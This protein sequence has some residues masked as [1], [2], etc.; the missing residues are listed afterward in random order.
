MKIL[1]I[2]LLFLASCLSAYSLYNPTV[3]HGVGDTTIIS[4]II[5]RSLP[6]GNIGNAPAKLPSY[7]TAFAQMVV[8]TRGTAPPVSTINMHTNPTSQNVVQGFSKPYTV[9]YRPTTVLS[10]VITPKASLPAGCS[11]VFTP[12]MVPADGGPTSAAVACSGSST[13]GAKTISFGGTSGSNSGTVTAAMNVVA[14]CLANVTGTSTTLSL[15][16]D[17]QAAV[18]KAQGGDTIILPDNFTWT[19]NLTLPYRAANDVQYITIR[20]SSAVIAGQR[21]LPS[22]SLPTL[23]S[24]TQDPVIANDFNNSNPALRT[25]HHWKVSGVRI[26]S[27]SGFSGINY[28]Y[29]YFWVPPVSAAT[30]YAQTS[31]LSHDLMFDHIFIHGADTSNDIVRGVRA[32]ANN[33][34]FVD[35]YIDNIRSQSYEANAFCQV[36]TQGGTVL[37]NNFLESAGEN[38]F[39]GAG[40]DIFNL[41]GSGYTV[42]NNYFYKRFSWRGGIYTV[43]NVLEWKSGQNAQVDHN[44]FENNWQAQQSG[45]V[46]L[47]TPRTGNGTYNDIFVRNVNFTD[48]IIRHAPE[49]VSML[50]YDNGAIINGSI[51]LAQAW[52]SGNY[53][54]RNNWMDDMSGCLYANCGNA[55]GYGFALSGLPDSMTLDSNTVNFTP[56]S[57]DQFG[58]NSGLYWGSQYQYATQIVGTLY[59]GTYPNALGFRA[60]SNLFAVEIHCDGNNGATCVPRQQGD[61]ILGVFT[62]NAVFGSSGS[63]IP[64][65]TNQ[66]PTT[67]VNANPNNVGAD[68]TALLAGECSIKTGNRSEVSCTPGSYPSNV[69]P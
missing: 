43:K 58:T 52:R 20:R 63:R 37:V 46:V 65:W 40:P 55:I 12:A 22:D 56:N 61:S 21:V 1:F 50:D 60:L 45:A 17:L 68:T 30:F 54:F 19:G 14:C 38:V 48:N 29:I 5:Y 49:G 11:V 41:V 35:G 8:L 51:P 26:G 47:L 4:N 25:T 62:T 31:D 18:N 16:D 64:D 2:C 9:Y 10:S 32:D 15:G 44:V 39:F 23:L 36:T 53:T 34:S 13:A 6:A 69:A 24:G 33:V 28:A 42:Q 59:P 27:I 3:T 67:T 7:W 57:G 66:F